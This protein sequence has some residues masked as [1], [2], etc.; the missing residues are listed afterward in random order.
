LRENLASNALVSPTSVD[1]DSKGRQVALSRLE[2]LVAA[3]NRLT[4]HLD[5]RS[6]AVLCLRILALG[7]KATLQELG[8]RFGLTRERIR[9]LEVKTEGK[10]SHRLSNRDNRNFRDASSRFHDQLGLVFPADQLQT[11]QKLL[12]ESETTREHTLLLPL[13]LWSAGPYEQVGDFLVRAPAKK[14]VAQTRKIIRA[15]T[16][17]GPIEAGEVSEPLVRLGIKVEFHQ[18]WIIGLGRFRRLP[19]PGFRR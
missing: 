16:R 8:T 9:Q 6:L 3:A 5:E 13:L 1:A 10:V 4:A 18:R 12:S 19:A 15:L 14:I 2:E 17:G 7:E 11:L